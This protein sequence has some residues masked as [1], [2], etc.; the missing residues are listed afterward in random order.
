M[1]GPSPGSGLVRLDAIHYIPASTATVLV[2]A[3]A[4]RP[5]L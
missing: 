3:M 1:G 5:V 2:A 4:F